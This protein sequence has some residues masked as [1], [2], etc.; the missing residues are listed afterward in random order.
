LKATIVFE[1]N[2]K[3]ISQKTANGDFVYRYIVNRGSSRSSKTVSLCQVY[4][5]YARE[6]I[7]QRLTVW[8][9]TKTDCKKTVMNDFIKMLKRENLYKVN[10][11]YNKTE[12]IF[13]YTTDST[14]EIHGTDDEETV[15]GLNQ[16]VAWFN[17]PYKISRDTFDQIDQRTSNFVFIDYNPKK[18]HWVEDL[19]KDPRTLVIDSTFR[20]NPFCPKEQRAKILSYQPVSESFIVKSGALQN[21]DA[22]KYDLVGNP[23]NFEQKHITELSRCRL[24]E[25]KNSANLFNFQVYALGTKAERPNRILHWTEIPDSK[26]FEINT[27]IYYGVDWGKVDPW[28]IVELKYYDGAIYLN[29]LNYDSENKILD[30]LN[31]TERA[32][33]AGNEEGIVKWMF[34]KLQIPKNA[35]IICDNNRKE[36]IR[37]LWNAGYDNA[38]AATKTTVVEGVNILSSLT[39]YYTSSSKNIAY[40]QENYSRQVDRYGI[41]LEEPEDTNNHIIDPCRYIVNFLRREN[42][43]KTI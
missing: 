9:D 26:Y 30:K 11:E 17:E 27:P 37:A 8:R 22:K 33:I 19:I 28:G 24:N 3:A 1:K 21:E 36:K 16:D 25:D 4:D 14:V 32:Q 12:S 35:D 40:E 29:E 38:M 10:Q 41:V 42:I 7:S 5:L 34:D 39:V 15:M 31:D 6:N 23:L 43:I 20:D 18:D 2:W 13:T